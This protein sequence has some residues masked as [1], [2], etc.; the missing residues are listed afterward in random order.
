MTVLFRDTFNRAD[1]A[2]SMGNGWVVD[3]ASDP[4][5]YGILSNQAVLKSSAFP[6]YNSDNVFQSIAVA[7]CFVQLKTNVPIIAQPLQGLAGGALTFR[8]NTTQGSKKYLTLAAQ[9]NNTLRIEEIFGG[10]FSG[11]NA[12]SP[13]IPGVSKTQDLAVYVQGSNLTVY[14]NGISVWSLTNIGSTFLNTPLTNKGFGFTIDHP[15]AMSATDFLIQDVPGITT[16][17]ITYQAVFSP[18][19]VAS[20]PS[21]FEINYIDQNGVYQTV[22]SYSSNNIWSLSFTGVLDNQYYVSARDIQSA[23]AVTVN[24]YENGVLVATANNSLNP[25]IRAGVS[26]TI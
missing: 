7:D 9:P 14:N 16:P 18:G 22:P 15:G 24:V 6:G 19:Q 20:S 17:T 25:N 1:N 11:F 21:T 4:T 8:A 13:V 3:G 2:S 12:I 10:T 23:Y 5:V 26:G